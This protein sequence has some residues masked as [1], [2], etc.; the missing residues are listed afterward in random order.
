MRLLLLFISLTLLACGKKAPH[1]GARDSDYIVQKSEIKEVHHRLYFSNIYGKGQKY[2]GHEEVDSFK[3]INPNDLPLEVRN[4]Y[5]EIL[6]Q[7][8]KDNVLHTQYIKDK[9]YGESKHKNYNVLIYDYDYFLDLPSEIKLSSIKSIQVNKFISNGIEPFA[10]VKA[11]FTLKRQVDPLQHSDGWNGEKRVVKIRGQRSAEE[12]FDLVILGDGFDQTE[13]ALSTDEALLAS[14]FGLKAQE[15]ADA[16]LESAPFKSLKEKINV[17]L[18]ATPSVESGASFPASNIIK[19]TTFGAVFGANCHNRGLILQKQ[20]RAVE[21]ASEAPFDQIVVLVNSEEYGGQGTDIA[22]FSLHPKHFKSVL[23]HELGHAI[24]LFRDE[25]YYFS[26]RKPS[27]YMGGDCEDS[28]YRDYAYNIHKESQNEDELQPNEKL[29][30]RNLTLNNTVATAR[31]SHLLHKDSPVV[32]FDFAKTRLTLD[33]KT[34]SIKGNFSAQMDKDS[35]LFI[36]GFDN[37]NKFITPLVKS[38]KINQESFVLGNGM[39]IDTVGEGND[40]YSFINLAS[41]KVKKGE[42]IEVELKFETD[43]KTLEYIERNLDDMNFLTM[44]SR[45]F[46]PNELGLYQ[47]AKSD[48]KNVFRATYCSYMGSNE[49][50]VNKAQEEGLAFFID[51]YSRGV[52]EF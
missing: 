26:E 4:E 31:W 5:L 46:K 9:Y 19:R 38:I 37:L 32:Y 44:P 39:L 52:F 3:V 20:A 49:C 29:L 40:A 42:V 24:S 8:H 48:I 15:A 10:S 6:V 33:R 27:S 45:T 43:E 1:S 22:T 16:L 28:L 7:D 23:I 34:K 30:A 47:G 21:F 41:L 50:P 17:W 18:V 13:M 51:N 35:L 14:K 11:D 25:Y 2:L 12:A 36:F